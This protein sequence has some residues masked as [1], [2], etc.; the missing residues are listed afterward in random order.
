M[1]VNS[2]VKTVIS[3]ILAETC[4]ISLPSN[5]SE[6]RVRRARRLRNVCQ[7]IGVSMSK[8]KF[9]V[10]CLHNWAKKWMDFLYRDYFETEL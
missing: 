4:A 1:Y 6:T 8:I 9:A 5:T 7:K 2:I 3:P 10:T